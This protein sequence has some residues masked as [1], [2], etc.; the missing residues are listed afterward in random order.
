MK[1]GFYL[2]RPD[3]RNAFTN[4]PSKGLEDSTSVGDEPAAILDEFKDSF[5]LCRFR[6]NFDVQNS[7]YFRWEG[8]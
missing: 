6:Q 7:N 1:T 8:R 2:G 4:K 3:K 5:E